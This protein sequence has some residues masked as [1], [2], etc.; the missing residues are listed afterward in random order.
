MNYLVHGAK[1]Y[2]HLHRDVLFDL[3]AEPIIA[4]VASREI[5]DPSGYALQNSH[6][7]S[8]HSDRNARTGSTEAARRAGISPAVHAASMSVETATTI[9]VIS[10][11]FTS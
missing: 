4:T 5:P 8:P 10:T 6:T 1:V 11:P 7:K 2:F 9:T 3:F